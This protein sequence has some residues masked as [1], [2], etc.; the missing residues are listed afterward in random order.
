MPDLN[1]N[2]YYNFLGQRIKVGGFYSDFY[3][4]PFEL[5]Y[6]SIVYEE[7]FIPLSFDVIKYIRDH[8]TDNPGELPTTNKEFFIYAKPELVPE[9]GSDPV[10]SII[11]EEIPNSG[12]F[13]TGYRFRYWQ[14]GSSDYGYW[15]PQG[16]YSY[17]YFDDSYVGVDPENV[18]GED[19]W[20]QE[21]R[22]VYMSNIDGYGLPQDTRDRYGIILQHYKGSVEAAG[23]PY[24]Y[25]GYTFPAATDFGTPLPELD[26]SYPGEHRVFSYGT[27]FAESRAG[28]SSVVIGRGIYTAFMAQFDEAP[29]D[30]PG[31]WFEI[32]DDET[33]DLPD[34][35]YDPDGFEGENDINYDL[36]SK[37]VLTSGLFQLFYPTEAEMVAFADFLWSTDYE[38][39]LK[40]YGMKPMDNIVNFGII[41]F[42]L[43]NI[44][45]V[46]AE[47]Q[48]CGTPTGVRLSRANRAYQL[49]TTGTIYID[50]KKLSDSYLDYTQANFKLFIPCIGFVDLRGC[51]IIN[52]SVG[53]QYRIDCT[54]GDCI[55][56]VVITEGSKE[57]FAYSFT[58]NCLYKLPLTS[59]DYASYYRTQRTGLLSMMGSAGSV[60]G[61][62]MGGA[63]MG[64]PI[65]GF[66]AGLA[67]GVQSINSMWDAAES[68]KMNAPNVQRGG[69]FSGALSYLGY[70]VP[71]IIYDCPKVY[72]K[73]FYSSYSY[74]TMA[75]MKLSQCSG[76]TQVARVD[77]DGIAAT[78]T[79]KEMIRALLKDGVYIKS[80]T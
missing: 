57:W 61:A 49:Y 7:G 29:E 14:E 53:V 17:H 58:G 25:D 15:D 30:S 76:W 48:L 52:R 27:F 59:A 11:W 51:D 60:V 41:P 78:S 34:G 63:A 80:A 66:A 72:R 28:Y 47:V 62:A 71:Y 18:T 5:P 4:Y 73:G 8:N 44:R 70:P 69:E 16:F 32:D 31:N 23:G 74:P 75:R 10:M 36:P 54:T 64:G 79:E 21:I 55:A 77:L 13:R 46:T 3:V 37:S 12:R 67:A 56:Y 2:K 33:P 9:I 26:P 35:D 38:D 42:D 1:L 50:S 24:V 22:F 65:G 39:S 68:L 45:G 19:H 20:R 6:K 40:R 43:S